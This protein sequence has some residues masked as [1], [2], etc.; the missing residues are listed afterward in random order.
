MIDL[1]KFKNIEGNEKNRSE[2]TQIGVL[3]AI[4]AYFE[5]DTLFSEEQIQK[6]V[7]SNIT[8]CEVYA[9]LAKE[10]TEGSEEPTIDPTPD[11]TPNQTEQ[12]EQGEGEQ[13]Q[14]ENPQD[15]NIELE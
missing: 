5:G 9:Q 2:I 8:K 13:G 3:E 7:E 1:A 12:G 14:G 11:P 4:D 6:M 10:E 15:G